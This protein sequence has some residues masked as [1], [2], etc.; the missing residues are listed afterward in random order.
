MSRVLFALL[1]ALAGCAATASL[2]PRHPPALSAPLAMVDFPGAARV[3]AGIDAASDDDEWAVGDQL[4]FGLQLSKAGETRRWL[5]RLQVRRARL[6]KQIGKVHTSDGRDFPP[7]EFDANSYTMMSYTAPVDGET[8]SFERVSLALPV[9]VTIF[10]ADGSELGASEV[11]LPT[12]VLREGLLDAVAIAR[13]HP[14]LA[15]GESATPEQLRQLVDSYMSLISLLNV[16]KEDSV[17]AQYFWQVVEKP[18]L[19][20]ALTHFGIDVSID[21]QLQNS[22]AARAMPP[23]LPA[24]ERAVI[25][26]VRIDVNGSP[27]L[28][29]DV[30]A[31]DPRRPFSLCGG[32]VAAS[33]HHPSD[34]SLHFDVQVLAARLGPAK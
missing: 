32:M 7:I 1:P 25:V 23:L 13:A 9:A 4:L 26:P 2:A 3:L 30:L 20:S 33:A 22:V 31:T 19:W 5:M 16:V 17:L 6:D 28:S 34:P 27:A 11:L 14:A 21:I 12:E 10:D 15:T 24:S 18:S 8:R 29:V